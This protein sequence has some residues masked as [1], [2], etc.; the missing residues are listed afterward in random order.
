MKAVKIQDGENN[1][2]VFM[3]PTLAPELPTEE[4][5]PLLDPKKTTVLVPQEPDALDLF[6]EETK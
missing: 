2:I 3:P 6:N 4:H 1:R 5:Y